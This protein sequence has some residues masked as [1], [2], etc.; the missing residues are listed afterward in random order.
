[1]NY[2]RQV[3]NHV[4]SIPKPSVA[5]LAERDGPSGQ[6]PMLNPNAPQDRDPS[7]RRPTSLHTPGLIRIRNNIQLPHTLR[8]APIKDPLQPPRVL[9]QG[10][11]DSLW[12]TRARHRGLRHIAAQLLHRQGDIWAIG[13]QIV[14]DGGQDPIPV[15][16][17]LPQLLF[18][19]VRVGPPP[20]LPDDWPVKALRLRDQPL[21][22]ASLPGVLRVGP[23][24]RCLWK[25]T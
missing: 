8:P 21:G 17:G 15:R 2:E 11:G 24:I 3:P 23:W 1:M 25:S 13:L 9:Q 4:A 16:S 22:P 12:P 10:P 7:A 5:A 6:G 14:G 19:S 18:P 20:R